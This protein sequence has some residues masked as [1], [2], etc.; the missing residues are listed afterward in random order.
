[1]TWCSSVVTVNDV[2]VKDRYIREN[3]DDRQDAFAG[4][5]AP[6]AMQLAFVCLHA[7]ITKEKRRRFWIKSTADTLVQKLARSWDATE[8]LHEWYYRLFEVKRSMLYSS[9]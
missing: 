1:M 8:S 5:S 9:S 6:A 4:L 3:A 2:A 7:A